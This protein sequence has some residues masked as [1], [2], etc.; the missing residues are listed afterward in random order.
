MRSHKLQRQKQLEALDGILENAKLQ[1][2]TL[3]GI[4][5]SVLSVAAAV[6]K[7]RL[8]MFAEETATK[9]AEAALGISPAVAASQAVAATESQ[10]A[11]DVVA[12]AI[13]PFSRD[14]SQLSAAQLAYFDTIKSQHGAN[15][16][17]NSQFDYVK[18]LQDIQALASKDAVSG[19][20]RIQ[21]EA[22]ID[23]MIRHGYKYD[24]NTG[25]Y[26][27]AV[28]TN[29]VPYDG[30]RAILHEGEA[31]IPKA[32]NPAAGGQSS[33]RLESLVE[34]LTKEVQR[35]QSIVNDGNRQATRTAD[36][37]NGRPEMPMLVETV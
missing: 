23:Y 4:D 20:A 7:L 1:I 10:T 16:D 33:A 8:K 14:I 2:D 36:A 24:P 3:R 5:T 31:V 15:T 12:A 9:Q 25:G 29:Y 17:V 32:Y 21:G 19:V 11:Y 30:M 28:G 22:G 13:E 26:S 35:L 37:T 18:S 34:G 6:D 27:L